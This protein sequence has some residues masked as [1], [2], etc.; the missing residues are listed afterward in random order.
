MDGTVFFFFRLLLASL[1]LH[2]CTHLQA[3]V[4]FLLGLESVIRIEF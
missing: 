3:R 4:V 1:H 2:K